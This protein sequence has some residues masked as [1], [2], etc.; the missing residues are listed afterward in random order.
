MEKYACKTRIFS[1]AGAVN[2]L[3]ELG[4]ERLFL[5]SD[6]FFEKNGTAQSIASKAGT[7]E[8]EI[9][10]GVMPDPTVEQVAKG[11]AMLKTFAPD[12]VVALGGGI[13][14]FTQNAPNLLRI[15]FIL[16][17]AVGLHIGGGGDSPAV[18][19]VVYFIAIGKLGVQLCLRNHSGLVIHR[20]YSSTYYL[21]MKS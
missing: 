7:A 20:V 2:A 8:Y 19:D 18:P 1:G 9:Y 5:V 3:K 4:A 10:S 21:N 12:T 13:S 14:A 15:C 6:P 17:T 16:L 11:T